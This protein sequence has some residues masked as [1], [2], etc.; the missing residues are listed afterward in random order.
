LCIPG[1]AD[2]Q[3]DLFP[4]REGDTPKDPVEL[5][6]ANMWAERENHNCA[7]ARVVKGYEAGMAGLPVHVLDKR[8]TDDEIADW[9]MENGAVF[10]ARYHGYELY[11]RA[12]LSLQT[13]KHLVE[14]ARR[15]GAAAFNLSK[16]IGKSAEWWEGAYGVVHNGKPYVKPG[17]SRKTFIV[18]AF[19]Y[20][21]AMD[22]A[23]K[24]IQAKNALLLVG[25]L[26]CFCG[27]GIPLVIIGACL[28]KTMSTESIKEQVDEAGVIAPERKGFG[29]GLT[30]QY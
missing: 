29:M 26:L 2:I 8:F 12:K 27:I 11:G 16:S 19:N 24:N 4:T 23:T 18:L 10:M 22:I 7:N 13:L 15:D 30:R 14:K 6:Y 20:T 17:S 3:Y 9:F 28:P 1:L 21:K 5:K 25:C